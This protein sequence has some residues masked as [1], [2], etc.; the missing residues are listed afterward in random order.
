MP[1]VIIINI[2]D[3]DIVFVY[4]NT[5]FA[6]LESISDRAVVFILLVLKYIFEKIK[7]KSLESYEEASFIS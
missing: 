6:V 3:D 2:L 5:R 4:I 1:I 7:I